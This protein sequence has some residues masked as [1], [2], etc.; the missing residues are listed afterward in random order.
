MADEKK[1]IEVTSGPIKVGNQPAQTQNP[2]PVNPIGKP[3]PEV[4]EPAMNNPLADPLV[5]SSAPSPPLRAPVSNITTAQ[6][7]DDLD[8]A[9]REAQ[10]HA[11]DPEELRNPADH[12]KDHDPSVAQVT[13][14]EAQKHLDDKLTPGNSPDDPY[15]H[16]AQRKM[17]QVMF[18]SGQGQQIAGDSE[19]AI[20]SAMV[21]Q[22]G[23]DYEIV[24]IV[25]VPVEESR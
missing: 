24:S 6:K 9:L 19:D 2:L 4:K 5:V 18:K 12:V 15:H 22:Y 7:Q 21:K 13:N 3:K 1:T 11:K 14:I 10:R 20:R 16:A 8:N 25:P 23:E 17:W